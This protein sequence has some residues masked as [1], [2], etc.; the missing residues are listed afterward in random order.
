LDKSPQESTYA[1]GET[2]YVLSRLAIH[3]LLVAA[4]SAPGRH[5]VNHSFWEDKLVGDLLTL[6]NIEPADDNFS[7]CRRRKPRIEG[8]AVNMTE[9]AF[10][11]SLSTPN[12]IIQL[13]NADEF[14]FAQTIAK[15]N[16]LWPKK[17]WPTYVPPSI[18]QNSNQL[19]LLSDTAKLHRLLSEQI[20]IVTVI[21]NEILML[22]HFLAHHRHLG[23]NCFVFVDNCS[24]DGSREYLIGQPDVVLFSSDTDYKFSHYGVAWQQ[25]I[26]GNFCLGKWVLLADAD[27]LFVFKHCENRNIQDFTNEIA[28][29]N[30]DAV[31]VLMV[32]MYP[33]RSLDHADFSRQTPFVA[34]PMFDNPPVIHW[35]LGSGMYSNSM[36]TVSHFRHR[37]SANSE[38]HAFVSQKFAFFKYHSGIRL[39]EGLHYASNLK[40]SDQ[41]AWFAHFKYHAGFKQKVEIEI[42]RKQHF[43]NANEYI[44]YFNMLNENQGSF[45]KPGISIPFKSSMDFYHASQ[46]PYKIAPL[47]QNPET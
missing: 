20:L 46:K 18:N 47:D 16:E 26:L 3:E 44:S 1:S 33:E 31:T 32:D 30:F 35:H 29:N 23:F 21:R 8:I 45:F 6:R 7:V 36:S 27:E 17:I 19:E 25:A 37:V 4:D 22:P 43:N 2:A 15:K 11:P 13:K 34:A 5:I 41:V 39:S 42:Q 14:G 9:N 24:D 28:K 10:F 38:P 12:T 40:L